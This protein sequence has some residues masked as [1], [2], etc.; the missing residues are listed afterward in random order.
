M[1]KVR[2]L[3]IYSVV[4]IAAFLL[5]GCAKSSGS[6]IITGTVR[7]AISP[8]EVKIYLDPPSRYETIGLVEA[9]GEVGSSIWSS[10]QATQDQVIRELKSRAAKIGANGILLANTGTGSGGMTGF[11]SN[12]VFFASST[13]VISGQGRA[14]YVIEE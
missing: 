3:L 11:H 1:T 14:I 2:L 10:R 5:I 12:N 6:S 8:N 9:A 7:P 13:A 4:L